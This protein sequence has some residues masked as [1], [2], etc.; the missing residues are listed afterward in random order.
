MLLA[1]QVFEQPQ[2]ACVVIAGGT[3]VVEFQPC[4]DAV[5]S[6]AQQEH[7]LRAA[8]LSRDGAVV[9]LHPL[10]GLTAALHLGSKGKSS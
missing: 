6:C 7:C 10:Q 4:V 2:A 8:W 1:A 9:C 3:Q 5:D